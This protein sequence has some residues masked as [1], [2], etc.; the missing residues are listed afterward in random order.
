MLNSDSSPV[1]PAAMAGDGDFLIGI[2]R[3]EAELRMADQLAAEDL[4]QHR[5]GHADDAD[6]GAK[7]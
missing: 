2:E 1:K 3:G 6:P 4:L 7:R 5:R